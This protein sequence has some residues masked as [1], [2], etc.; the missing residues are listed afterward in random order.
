MSELSAALEKVAVA[1]ATEQG[2]SDFSDVSEQTNLF[3][4]LD[5]FSVVNLLL[6]TEMELEK[7]TGTYTS[8]ADQTIFDAEKSPLL[9][10]SSWV[11]Y[12]ESRIV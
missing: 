2:V 3:D 7:I 4:V 9:K 6:E 1:V 8:I 10:W 11:E 12:V 5:S